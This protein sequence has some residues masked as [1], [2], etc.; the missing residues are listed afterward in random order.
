MTIHDTPSCEKKSL[1][2]VSLQHFPKAGQ[3][4]VT[5]REEQK[6]YADLSP[7][8]GIPLTM[9]SRLQINIIIR[10]DPDIDSIR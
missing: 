4:N 5:W 8:L 9:K 10:R 2:S 1:L 7:S 6:F 3:F